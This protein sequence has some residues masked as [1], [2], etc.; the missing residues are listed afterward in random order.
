MPTAVVLVDD[1]DLFRESLGRNLSD[2]GYAVRDFARGAAALD[3]LL[4]EPEPAALVILDWRMPEM[5]GIEVLKRIRGANIDVPAIFLTALTDQIYEEAALATGAVDFVEK[6]RSFTIL[7][8]RIGLI[9]EGTKA[10][11]AANCNEAET[12]ELGA[13]ALNFRT[14]RALWRERPVEL[15]LTEFKIVRQLA[16]KAGADVPYREIYDL[17]HGAG[18]LAGAGP[19]GYRANVR[20]FVKRIRQKFRDADPAFDMIGNY[21]GFGYRWK[22]GDDA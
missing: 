12:L 8:K 18:F 15:T 11:G 4:A 20:T 7:E 17:V 16:E 14:S 13:L 3:H 2:A 10:R 21:A 5:N 19:E 6:S 22:A 9:L 1:D